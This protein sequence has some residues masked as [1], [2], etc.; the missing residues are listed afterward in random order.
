M[1][2]NRCSYVVCINHSFDRHFHT[3]YGSATWTCTA[4]QLATSQY[5]LDLFLWIHFTVEHVLSCPKDNEIRDF[6]AHLMAEVCHNV[7]VEPHLQ[8]LTGEILQGASPITQDGARLDVAADDFWGSRFERAFFDVKVFNPYAPSNRTSTLQACY[9][10][11]ENIKKRAYDQR[12]REVE[13]R[14]F[15]PLVFSCTGGMSR[16]STA[17][18]KRLAALIAER[19]DKPY[20]TTMGWIR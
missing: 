9:R 6:T 3:T 16:A 1:F 2:E 4:L 13:H 7:A 10:T 8:P 19:R 18:Y 15:S 17:T 12:I 14:T 11:H 5:P 20:C